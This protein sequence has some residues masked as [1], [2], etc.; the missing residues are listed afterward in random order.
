MYTHPDFARRGV[1]RMILD[2][3]EARARSEG[4]SACE[5]AATLSGEPLYLACGYSPIRRFEAVSSRGV[6]VPLIQMG[7]A[8]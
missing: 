1:G 3:C 7:K 4:F 5:L 2:D 8:L 6:V